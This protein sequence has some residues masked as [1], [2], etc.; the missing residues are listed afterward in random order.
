MAWQA[1][2]HTLKLMTELIANR[3][4]PFYSLGLPKAS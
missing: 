1:E 4:G 2:S 3:F